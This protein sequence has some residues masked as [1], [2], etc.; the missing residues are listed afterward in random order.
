MTAKKPTKQGRILEGGGNNFSS[1]PEY[2]PLRRLQ[3]RQR[4]AF[5]MPMSA[6]AILRWWMLAVDVGDER[7]QLPL[8]G[9][10]EDVISG[11]T[12]VRCSDSS[13]YVSP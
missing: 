11:R 1:W 2:I 4:V 9:W 13:L 7:R 8:A 3:G 5:K 6:G 12:S 10:A